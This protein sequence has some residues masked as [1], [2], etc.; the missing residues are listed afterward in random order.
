MTQQNE[1]F[2]QEQTVEFSSETSITSEQVA[3]FGGVKEINISF[4]MNE[5]QIED[6]WRQAALRI[7]EKLTV[8]DEQDINKEAQYWDQ[9]EHWL[10]KGYQRKAKELALQVEQLEFK[11]KFFTRQLEQMELTL[12]ESLH[13]W[14]RGFQNNQRLVINSKINEV[15]NN[16]I[17]IVFEQK[18]QE[19]KD[20]VIQE[21]NID[22][23]PR[24]D[25][26]VNEWISSHIQEIFNGIIDSRINIFIDNKLKEF[27]TSEIY[28]I[29]R[30]E[31]NAKVSEIISTIRLEIINNQIKIIDI[32]PIRLEIEH[33]VNVQ[34]EE[35]KN[36]LELQIKQGDRQLY[37][38]ILAQLSAIKGCLTDRQ[39][40][41]E[42]AESFS[43]QLKTQLDTAAY[44]NTSFA[45]WAEISSEQQLSESGEGRINL[46][47]VAPGETIAENHSIDIQ[48][49]SDS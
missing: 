30:S 2:S 11:M 24:I 31:I 21:I 34:I 18:K 44:V 23:N 22:F 28:T 43:A 14:A 42:L 39:A 12:N 37:E 15:V 4:E 6:L 45:S 7:E 13:A 3:E 29:I 41:V 1:E 16:N 36:K 47:N 26:R 20:L 10:L 38:W 33:V 46:Q 49:Q 40:L 32:E 25:M 27:R 17:N 48:I 35:I 8:I 5:A 9:L 19:I